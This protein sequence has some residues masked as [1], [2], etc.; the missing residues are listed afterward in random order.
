MKPSLCEI[1]PSVTSPSS[2]A[3]II[4]GLQKTDILKRGNYACLQEIVEAEGPNLIRFVAARALTQADP[5][6]APSAVVSVFLEVLENAKPIVESYKPLAVRGY[7]ALDE[8]CISLCLLGQTYK[9]EIITHLIPVLDKYTGFNSSMMAHTLLY[10]AFNDKFE[11][12]K[13]GFSSL[14]A[15][16]QNILLKILNSRRC[17]RYAGNMSESLYHFGLPENREALRDYCS[18]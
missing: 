5:E 16:Q 12:V 11:G 10:F 1:L 14:S 18:N 13:A 7:D 4:L 17:W 6:K 8:V 9:D 15:T 3:K 2:A